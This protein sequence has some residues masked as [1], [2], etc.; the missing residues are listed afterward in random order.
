MFVLRKLNTSKV[1]LVYKIF[2]FYFF[3]FRGCIKDG[4]CVSEW[5]LHFSE[6]MCCIF[7]DKDFRVRGCV[8]VTS[9][10]VHIVC[11]LGC[12]KIGGKLE[13]FSGIITF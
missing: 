3:V 5:M 6:S 9:M 2:R 8:C 10:N 4:K 13:F 1:I 12:K 7:I 11:F